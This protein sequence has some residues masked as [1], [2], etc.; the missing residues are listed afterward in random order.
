MFAHLLTA[1]CLLSL[2]LAD[3][4]FFRLTT[5]GRP[6]RTVSIRGVEDIWRRCTISSTTNSLRNSHTR[7]T[8]WEEPTKTL[9]KRGHGPITQISATATGRLDKQDRDK[10]TTNMEHSEEFEAECTSLRLPPSPNS[11]LSPKQIEKILDVESPVRTG[12]TYARSSAYNM[13]RTDRYEHPRMCRRMLGS[14]SHTTTTLYALETDRMDRSDFWDRNRNTSSRI[15]TKRISFFQSVI[16]A[17]YFVTVYV[18]T[19]PYYAVK[20]VSSQAYTALATTVY[21]IY[22]YGVSVPLRA[23]RTV[24]TTVASTLNDAILYGTSAPACALRTISTAFYSAVVTSTYYIY[25]CVSRSVFPTLAVRE[26][27]YNALVE[28]SRKLGRF[29]SALIP[30]R[31]TLAWI[32][33]LLLLPIAVLFFGDSLKNQYE[34]FTARPQETMAFTNVVDFDRIRQMIKDSIEAELDNKLKSSIAIQVQSS[35]NDKLK[36]SVDDY[37]KV[38][39]KPETNAALADADIERIRTMIKESID[40]DL[41]SSLD[42]RLKSTIDI[43]LQTSFD[44]KLKSLIDAYFKVHYKPESNAAL[45]DTDIEKIRKSIKDSLHADLESSLDTKLKSSIDVQLQSSFDEKLKSLI[46]SYLK[47]HY[48]PEAN[49]F[50]DVDIAQIRKVIQESIDVDLESSLDA[51][52]K[53]SIDLQLQSSFD[54]KLKSLIDDYLKVHYKVS[55]NMAFSDVDIERIRRMIKESLDV[56]DADKTGMAD[57]ALES[58]GGSVLSTRCTVPYKET[59]RLESIYGIPLWYSSYS[60]RSVIQRKSQGATAGECWAFTGNHGYLAVQLASRV[61]VTAVSYEHLPVSVSP[62]G[63]IKSAPKEFLVWSY[64]TLDDTNTRVLL[65]TFEYDSYGSAI[66]TFPIQNKDPRG[67]PIIE[68]EVLSNYGSDYTCLYRFRVHGNLTQA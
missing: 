17:V 44:E 8:G 7:L 41:E 43:Q 35:L 59:S 42:T 27:Y 54:E 23:V 34:T 13:H 50:T 6:K 21:Y 62:Q 49:G 29:A 55:G 9:I 5:F 46:D 64:Q 38:H 48:K 16:R 4:Q 31:K 65:G 25:E 10:T 2:G 22:H 36:S 19:S 66:Q 20:I 58:A 3:L 67:T 45:T 56:Y 39:Y 14:G 53:S 51:K 68:L 57:Y 32:F 33:F 26:N 37:L 24:L 61:N 15:E 52:L 28:S 60:P 11:R 40:L 47:V 12:F 1:L 30:S 63:H 18:L